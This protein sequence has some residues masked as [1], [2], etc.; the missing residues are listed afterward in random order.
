MDI[1]GL[2]LSG[3]ATLIALAGILVAV[4]ARADS[5][6]SADAAEAAELRASRPRLRVEP[7]GTV[8]RDA[9]DVIYRVR[10]MEGPD[11]TSVVVERPA[12]DP[13]DGG[14][15]YPVAATGRP[16]G[17]GDSAEIGPIPLTHYGRFTFC[18]GSGAT[19]PEFIV[20]ITCRDRDG[21]TWVIS[22]TLETPRSPAQ[23]EAERERLQLDKARRAASYGEALDRARG[24]CYYLRGGAGIG[25]DSPS[26]QM[27]S[28]HVNVRNDTHLAASSVRLI[29]GEG[30][31][32]WTPPSGRP[33]P[34][35]TEHEEEAKLNGE[36]PDAPQS[37]AGGRA[38]Q[39]Y[40]SR[41]EFT[42][43]GRRFARAGDGAPEILPDLS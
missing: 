42:L 7:E 19:L 3:V 35:N 25:T 2:M 21:R 27:T 14:V 9:T 32:S 40:P 24:V 31:F 30:A 41:L 1:A 5:R 16:G 33:I 22:E 6:R 10:N 11:L 39:S 13:A 8:Q 26:W 12:V 34:P 17:Y 15:T 43:G 18:L 4:R 36:L 20:K 23:L 37:E 38:F 28:L 29:I